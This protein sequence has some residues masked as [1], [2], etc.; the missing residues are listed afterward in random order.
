MPE[1]ITS[2]ANAVVKVLKSLHAKKGRAETGLFLAEGA[3]VLTE[4]GDAGH[5]PQIVAISDAA[6]ERAPVRALVAAAEA[7][8][9]RAIAVSEAL[10]AQIAKRENPQTIIGAFAQHARPLDALAG[11]FFVALEGVRDP[12]NLGTILRSA[13]CVGASGVILVDQT[14]DPFSVEAVRAS[15]GSI[16]TM[17][18][19]RAPFAAL[20]AWRKARGL[21]LVAGSL[22]GAWREDAYDGAKPIVLLMG[23][24]PSG[25]SRE[26]EAHAD[27]LVRLP[28]R[29]RADSLNLAA[30]TAVLLYD[31]W[32]RRGYHGA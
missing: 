19:A 23:N 16:F 15:M 13:D 26:Q 4:A 9:A 6:L 17:A 2:A 8:G 25:L 14:C 29:G 10:L 24:E 27:A 5:W 28:M 3:R 1:R 21:A 7:R 12:G 32:R 31:I 20:D 18:F 11:D 22:N 30:A